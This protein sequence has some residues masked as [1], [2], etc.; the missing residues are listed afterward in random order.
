MILVDITYETITEESAEDGE[1]AENGFLKQDDE[2]TFRE[3]IEW[4]KWGEPSA[5][6]ASGDT[7]E[8]VQQDQG[9]TR[10]WFEQGEREYRAIHFSRNNPARKAKYWAKAMKAAGLM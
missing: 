1:A 7:W 2:M 9:E 3:L 4:M 8:W 6:P 10:A 5:S